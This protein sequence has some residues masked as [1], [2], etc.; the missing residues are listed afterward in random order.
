MGYG[1]VNNQGPSVGWQTPVR[2]Q[3]PGLNRSV[4]SCGSLPV[5][6][7]AA[8]GSASTDPAAFGFGGLLNLAA[9]S[10]APRIAFFC[11]IWENVHKAR[12]KFVSSLAHAVGMG[13][14]TI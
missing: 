4:G 11:P 9:C 5:P 10:P 1:T 8:D 7:Y 3:G 14:A 2:S 6:G 12:N 13:G